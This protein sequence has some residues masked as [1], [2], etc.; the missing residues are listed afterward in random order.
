MIPLRQ[1]GDVQPRK[2]GQ[3]FEGLKTSVRRM[4]G[5][6][7]L[8]RSDTNFVKVHLGPSPPAIGA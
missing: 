1:D 8:R 6:A 7:K 3:G 5:L 2:V 4:A